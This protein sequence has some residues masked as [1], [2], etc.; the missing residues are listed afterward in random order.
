MTV[1]NYLV[2]R[3]GFGM[4]KTFLL[5]LLCAALFVPGIVRA[6]TYIDTFNGPAFSQDMSGTGDSFTRT[7]SALADVI[8][9]TRQLYYEQLFGYGSGDS[10]LLY[11]GYFTTNNSIAGASF[12]SL[13]Y[14]ANGAGLNADLSLGEELVVSWLPDHVGFGKNSWMAFTLTDG[15]GASYK[16]TEVWGTPDWPDSYDF[17]TTTFDLGDFA[18]NGVS[19]SNIRSIFFEY[20]S[21]YANDAAFD[22][23]KVTTVP[24][25]M[26]VALFMLGAGA[27]GLRLRKRS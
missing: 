17:L 14:D 26:S 18:D 19:L 1:N 11:P 2:T 12:F 21:D 7:D 23:L 22:F 25:P 13:L 4:K 10:A 15:N 5:V 16:S 9:G 20:E 24:E 6:D 27:L 3:K 8:G